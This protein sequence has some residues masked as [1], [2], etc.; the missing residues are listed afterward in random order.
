MKLDELIEDDFRE[1]FSNPDEFGGVIVH[2]GLEKQIIESD[3]SYDGF[4]TQKDSNF[5]YI[6]GLPADFRDIEKNQEVIY[7]DKTYY[8]HSWSFYDGQIEIL[9]GVD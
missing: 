1:I 5:L 3:P 9:L 8:I 7:K 4:D 6:S 2:N